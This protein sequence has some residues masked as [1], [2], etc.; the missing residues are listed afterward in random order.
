MSLVYYGVAP[1]LDLLLGGSFILDKLF[2]EKAG[3]VI[4]AVWAQIKGKIDPSNWINVET[5]GSLDIFS[6]DQ[7]ILTL[8]TV[9]L[10]G[11]TALVLNTLEFEDPVAVV[12]TDLAI[13]AVGATFALNAANLT[14]LL[15]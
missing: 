11:I 2:G 3:G 12:I 15:R 13:A 6:Q 5:D 14:F 4:E 8:L 9:D 1:L 10:L 7:Q